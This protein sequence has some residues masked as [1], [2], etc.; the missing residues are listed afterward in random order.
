MRSGARDHCL[1]AGAFRSS[2]MES[3]TYDYAHNLTA[4]GGTGVS[5]VGYTWDAENRLIE[6]VP[7]ED[8]PRLMIIL[9]IGHVRGR[10]AS[11]GRSAD[12]NEPGQPF[13][14]GR[15]RRM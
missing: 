1:I 2:Q 3:F 4:V 10:L 8:D 5:P 13:M 7:A 12:R 15:P 11:S 14:G 6:V 9:L